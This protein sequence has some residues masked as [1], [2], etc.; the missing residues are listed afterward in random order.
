MNTTFWGPSGWQFLHTL[1]FI[2]PE[3]PTFSDKVKMHEFMYS[4]SFIL[5]CKYCRLSFTKYI[6]SLPIDGYLDSRKLIVEW[7]YKIHN[8]IN[9][10]LRIQGFCK[11]SNPELSNVIKHYESITENIYKMLNGDEKSN[12]KSNKGKNVINYI[13]NLGSDFLGSVVFN[14]QGYFTNCHTGN[15][16]VKIVSVYNTFFNSIIPMILAYIQKFCKEGKDCVAR[17]KEDLRKKDEINEKNIKNIKNI[18]NFNIRSIL[19]QNE[20]YSK[21]VK[22]FYNCDDL[23]TMKDMYTSEENYENHFKKHIVMSCDNPKTSKKTK[24]CRKAAFQKAAF[25]KSRTK[26]A[27]RKS[28]AKTFKKI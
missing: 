28:R 12:E 9:K 13:C 25:R 16:K 20:P 26:A 24:T 23:C 19:S 15:E 7:L 11:H 1:T 6:K 8:K 10:K 3:S 5:P 21:L 4:L 14:Y 22:W 2:Y 18:K 17:Y 27:F